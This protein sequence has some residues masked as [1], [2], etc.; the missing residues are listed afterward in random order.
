MADDLARDQLNDFD[1][2]L[3]PQLSRQAVFQ[4]FAR[5]LFT[6]WEFP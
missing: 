2:Q 4:R 5:L 3:F 1:P 6:P